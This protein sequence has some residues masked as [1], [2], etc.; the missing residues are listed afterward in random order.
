MSELFIRFEVLTF[1]LFSGDSQVAYLYVIRK[2]GFTEV[3]YSVFGT[4][5]IVLGLVGE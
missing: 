2:F 3:E 4:I 1:F 5:N